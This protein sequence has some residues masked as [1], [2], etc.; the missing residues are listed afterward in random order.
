MS[1]TPNNVLRDTVLRVSRAGM[2]LAE[3]DNDDAE[4]LS[5]AGQTTSPDID[6]LAHPLTSAGRHKEQLAL[7]TPTGT[8]IVVNLQWSASGIEAR[9]Y[10]AGAP[11]LPFVI[12][13][14][15][16]RKAEPATW[17]EMGPLGHRDGWSADRGMLGFNPLRASIWR[18]LHLE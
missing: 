14:G 15:I 13:I 5:D 7:A 16:A 11:D 2:S 3:C 17:F 12:W 18:K 10:W 8:D 1:T 9:W 4:Q 6:F